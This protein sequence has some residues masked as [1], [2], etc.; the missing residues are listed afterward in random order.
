MEFDNILEKYNHYI[1]Y[2]FGAIAENVCNYIKLISEVN[3]KIGKIRGYTCSDNQLIAKDKD[4]MNISYISEYVEYA[5]EDLVIVATSAV[6]FDVILENLKTKDLKNIFVVDEKL[7]DFLFKFNLMV[8]KLQCLKEIQKEVVI[9]R[10]ND[11]FSMIQWI[12]Q[13]IIQFCGE[14]EQI[15]WEYIDNIADPYN[16]KVFVLGIERDEWKRV[17]K[18]RKITSVVR[19]ED[20]I[21]I[22]SIS[23]YYDES[24]YYEPNR[25]NHDLRWGIIETIAKEIYK[26]HIE[27]CVC[28]VGVYRGDS[29]RYINELFPDRRFFLFDS[30]EGFDTEE[31]QHEDQKGVYN[32]KLDYSNTTEE[33]VM[34]KMMYPKQCIIKKGYFPKTA[35]GVNEKFAFVRLDVDLYESTKAGL[36]FFSKRMNMGGM[37]LVHDCRNKNFDGASIALKEY[38][39]KNKLTYFIMPDELGTAVIKF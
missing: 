9:V 17:E 35:E 13:N 33:I 37:I 12:I 20:I 11:N 3:S 32:F 16:G 27:G 1:I 6:H 10:S 39:D 15:S 22:F 30:F 19:I 7:Q 31:Q 23:M 24:L 26:N 5:D 2:G 18:Y 4:G 28:E 21:D 29:A 34:N 14:I 25:L 38:C 36:D 8:K